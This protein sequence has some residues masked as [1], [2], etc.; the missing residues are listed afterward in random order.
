[1]IAYLL[2]VTSNKYAR[3]ENGEANTMS[4][5]VSVDMI[6]LKVTHT[7]CALSSWLLY[8]DTSC[9][10]MRLLQYEF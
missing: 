9:L 6:M 10:L 2:L 4:R 3:I 5:K 1:M 7:I 8:S